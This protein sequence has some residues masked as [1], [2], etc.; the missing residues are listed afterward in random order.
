MKNLNSNR[1]PQTTA[2]PNPIKRNKRRDSA[3]IKRFVKFVARHHPD[4]RPGHYSDFAQLESQFERLGLIPQAVALINDFEAEIKLHLEQQTA[5]MYES[6]R[7]EILNA[8][9]E[10]GIDIREFWR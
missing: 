7:G 1:S 6:L 2:F 4:Q 3:V 5:L 9:K 10:Q 8:L